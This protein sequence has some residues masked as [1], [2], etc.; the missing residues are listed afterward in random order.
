MVLAIEES[1][2]PC[3]K[4]AQL[5]FCEVCS[6]QQQGLHSTIPGRRAADATRATLAVGIVPA[7]GPESGR[8]AHVSSLFVDWRKGLHSTIPRPRA[9]D[10]IDVTLAINV[11]RAGRPTPRRLA[12]AVGI[13]GVVLATL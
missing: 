1:T 8:F 13:T 10:T 7:R 12:P 9:T 2:V 5:N 4:L 6:L 11:V 3:T